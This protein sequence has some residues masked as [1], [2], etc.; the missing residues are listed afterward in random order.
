M[1]EPSLP[2]RGLTVAEFSHAIMGPSAGMVLADLGAEVIK[3]EPAPDGDPTRRL[4]G[5]GVGFFGF[6]NRNKKSLA[7]DIK[8]LRARPVIETLLRKSDVLIE[9]FAAGTMDRLGL[10]YDAVSRLNPRLV[11]ASLK[12]F[13][14]GPYEQRR[15]LDEVVQMMSGLAYMTGPPGRPLRAGASVIDVMGGFGA[16][17]GILAALRERDHTGKG[18]HVASGLYEAAAFL[19]GQHMVNSVYLPGPL[20]PMSIRNSAWG[21]YDI[22]ESREGKPIFIGIVTDTQWKRF[23]AVF[24]RP[25]LLEVKDFESNTSRV[26]ARERLVPLLAEFFKTFP[27]TALLEKCDEA[28][29]AFAPVNTP[30][31]LFDDPH[32][33]ADG[34]L[35]ESRMPDGKIVKVPRLPIEI[36]SAVFTVRDDP[37]AAGEDTHEVLRSLGLEEA[38]IDD[39]VRAGVVTVGG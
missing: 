24:S 16:V 39:L 11:Y 25:D 29:L 20:Q 26:L 19:M 34:R 21:V 37:P 31:D 12:G 4:K 14:S 27:A 5:S 8:S 6:Y 17:I 30:V 7:I 35:R 2:L 36:E 13:L 32:L 28:E 15:A 23:C 1:S 38:Q 10:G 9:N 18:G 3:V 22:F 33:N